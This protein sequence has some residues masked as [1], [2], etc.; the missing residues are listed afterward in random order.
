[1]FGPMGIFEEAKALKAEEQKG[2]SVGYEYSI[3]MT[4]FHKAF[5]SRP[6]TRPQRLFVNQ[7]EYLPVFSRKLFIPHPVN[8]N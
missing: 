2:R 8:K 6:L 5:V 7:T 3:M 1:M 4:M